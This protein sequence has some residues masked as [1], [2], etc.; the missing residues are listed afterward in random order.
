MIQ[1]Y[2]LHVLYNGRCPIC[3]AEIRNYRAQ[4]QAAG[5]P[6]VFEDIDGA[7]LTEWGLDREAAAKR[8]H[9]RDKGQIVSGFPAFVLLWRE[10]PRMRWLAWVFDLPGLRVIAR[11]GYDWLAAPALYALHRRREA[12]AGR[13]G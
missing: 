10:L 6:V 4:A 3:S 9:V 1:P 11:M 2:T 12:R 8:F 7:D 13:A 5:A